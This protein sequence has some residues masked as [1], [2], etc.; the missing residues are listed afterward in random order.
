MAIYHFCVKFVS[1]AKGSSAV[2]AAA[3]RAAQRLTDD[4]Y[5]RDRDFT[6]KQGVVYSEIILPEGATQCLADRSTLWNVVEAR[7]VRRN[8]RLARDVEFAIPNELN[9]RQG[10]ALA[11]EFVAREF[12]AKGMIADLN[13]HWDKAADGSPRPHAHVML[14]TRQVGPDGFGLKVREWDKYRL[15]LEWRQSWAEHANVHL[16]QLGIDARIDHRRLVAQGV[17]LEAQ[18]KIGPA[19]AR[20]KSRGQ[21][22]DRVDNTLRI[23]RENGYKILADPR[24]ALN[25]ITHAHATFTVRDLAQFCFRHS[26]GKDQFD[27]LMSAVFG[28]PELVALGKDGRDQERFTSHDMIAVESQLGLSALT[29]VTRKRHAVARQNQNAALKSAADRGFILSDAQR[30]GFDH[31]M[32]RGDLVSVVGCAGSGKSAMLGVARDAWEREGYTVRGASLSGTGAER[33]EGSSG[34][35]S[36]PIANFECQWQQDRELLGERDVFVVDEAGLAGTRQIE[37]TLSAARTAG[38]KVVLVGDPGHLRAIEVGAPLRWL[39]DAHGAVEITER[40]RQ[41]A[42]WQRDATRALARGQTGEAIAAYHEHGTVHAAPTRAAARTALVEGWNRARA[43]SPN[44]SRLILA[45]TYAE[46][47]ALNVAARAILRERG[48]LGADFDVKTQF[49]EQRFAAGDRVIFLSNEHGMKITNGTLGTVEDVSPVRMTVRTDNEYRAA[50]DLR[51][52]AYIDHGYAATF[53]RSQGLTVDEAH[54]L[55]TS[56]MSRHST[57]VGLSRHRDRAQLYFGCDDFADRSEL[58]RDLARAPPEQIASPFRTDAAAA[59]TFARRRELRF[60]DGAGDMVETARDLLAVSEPAAQSEH[61]PNQAI[62]R[63]PS[64]KHSPDRTSD[65][66]AR[67]ELALQSAAIRLRTRVARLG[68]SVGHEAQDHESALD[69][70]E[71]WSG[72]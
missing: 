48:E 17:P 7:E 69:R 5:G 8:A 4:R 47:R 40:Q 57:Y 53:Q 61:R 71:E 21:D 45:Q 36:R 24:I 64:P 60:G 29:L 20:R 49:G 44:K 2:S 46:V 66:G 56:G 9:E 41:R 25:A 63:E 51:D 58:A 6:S 14:S 67:T 35:S 12:V 52:Y 43:K 31:I 10:I 59:R 39:V 30:C 19:A 72:R 13:V 26:N 11:R 16:A 34:I 62:E 33:L 54:I 38:A 32:S 18:T 15:L 3:Y 42:A 1:R 70:D 27:A 22:A 23:A 55:A 28:S 37:R 68:Q 65:W 50:F